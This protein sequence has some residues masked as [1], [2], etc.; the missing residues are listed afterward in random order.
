MWSGPV[1]LG[2][3]V[4]GDSRRAWPGTAL[5][6][7]PR[8]DPHLAGGSQCP[9]QGPQPALLHPAGSSSR[10]RP[11]Q[12]A[13][14]LI[15]LSVHHSSPGCPWPAGWARAQQRRAQPPTS[16]TRCSPP[17]GSTVPLPCNGHDTPT[18]GTRPPTLHVLSPSPRSVARARWGL[19]SSSFGLQCGPL[20]LGET[21]PSPSPQGAPEGVA[22]A[23]TQDPQQVPRV[24]HQ[25]AEPTATPSVPEE[26]VEE[27]NRA[28]GGGQRGPEV[29]SA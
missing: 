6:A 26:A 1:A 27:Q 22:T 9:F 11:P 3:W 8:P 10:G 20:F 7:H 16:A 23:Q 5:P 2:L 24:C 29:H 13:G 18:S 21:W 15:R 14:R 28:M 19:C 17:M 25:W 4:R 12:P